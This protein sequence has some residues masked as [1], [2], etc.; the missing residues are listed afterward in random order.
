MSC[1]ID[2]FECGC[3]LAWLLR[4]NRHLMPAVSG[5]VCNGFIKFEDVSPDSFTN[6]PQDFIAIKLNETNWDYYHSV[7]SLCIQTL[8]LLSIFFYKYKILTLD[9][10]RALHISF[11][12]FG[13]STNMIDCKYRNS[14]CHSCQNRAERCFRKYIIPVGRSDFF[15]WSKLFIG[16]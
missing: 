10:N 16:T 5:G 14:C 9:D 13:A 11:F 15:G 6:C 8:L 1:H 7:Y 3:G 4:D 2:P 12:P